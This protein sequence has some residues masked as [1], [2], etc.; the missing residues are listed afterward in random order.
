MT[1]PE[2]QVSEV[3][4]ETAQAKP[5]GNNILLLVLLFSMVGSAA[6]VAI[7][8]MERNSG[9]PDPHTTY[10]PDSHDDDY[11]HVDQ[12]DYDGGQAHMRKLADALLAY[13]Q[14][15]EGGGV[16]WPNELSEL[17]LFGLLEPDFDMT[18]RLSGEPVVYQPEMPINH[19]PSR[20]VLCHDIEIGWRRVANT[21]LS[22]KG[23][24]AA[25][26]ILGDG[27]VKLLQGDELEYYGGLN[28]QV[29][30]AR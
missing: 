13:R 10:W 14:G 27:T 3:P 1:E 6:G 21:G 11:Y 12:G 26:V 24:R 25:V 9:Q 28:L 29:E 20:W 4:L 16:R 15:P 23:P 2:T 17:R 7:W 5:R 30:S 22:S 8:W 18:G 19:D